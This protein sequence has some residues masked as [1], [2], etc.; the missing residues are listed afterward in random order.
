MQ[1]RLIAKGASTHPCHTID[2]YRFPG[3]QEKM[4]PVSKICIFLKWR[5]F[6]VAI[7]EEAGTPGYKKILKARDLGGRS[8]EHFYLS[9][10]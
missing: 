2:S 3:L 5:G 7:R 10:R 6:Q 9:R 4:T 8:R 1:G